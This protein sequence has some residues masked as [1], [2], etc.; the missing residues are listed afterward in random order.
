MGNT[1]NPTEKKK[2]LDPDSSK[3]IISALGGT[4]AVSQICGIKSPSVSQWKTSGISRP[5]LLFL[6]EKFSTLPV[7]RRPEVMDF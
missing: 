4:M 6:R 3:A 2:R 5:Y 1:A 7:M